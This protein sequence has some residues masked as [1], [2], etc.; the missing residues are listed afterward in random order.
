MDEEGRQQQVATVARYTPPRRR[1]RA[2]ATAVARVAR[3]LRAAAGV[4]A[5]VREQ[6][7]HVMEET[8]EGGGGQTGIG[9]KRVSVRRRARD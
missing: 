9:K 8:C 5:E 3:L 4:A 1:A 6:A 7:A 2:T